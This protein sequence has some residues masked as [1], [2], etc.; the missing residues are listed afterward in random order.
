MDRIDA[1]K[2][3]SLRAPLVYCIPDETARVAHAAFLRGNPYMRM[4]DTLSPIYTDPEFAHLFLKTRQPAEAPAQLAL[5]TVMQFAEGLSDTR[6]ADA[7]RSGID[8]KYALA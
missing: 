2:R 3:M 7:V 4:G 6:A 5:A 1:N 8:W